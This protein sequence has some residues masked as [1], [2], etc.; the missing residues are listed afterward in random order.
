MTFDYCQFIMMNILTTNIPF[1]N[2][3]LVA[4]RGGIGRISF[5]TDDLLDIVLP[6]ENVHAAIVL[7]Y[8]YNHS[9]LYYADVNIDVIKEVDLNNV[10]NTRNLISNG[11]RTTNGLA[12]DWI[13]NNLY[14]SDT[15]SSTI[16]VS[17][18]D[19]SSRKIIVTENLN[20]P[21][22]LAI[23]PQRGYLFFSDW[24]KPQRI[25]RCYLDGS[26]RKIIIST[27]LGFPTGLCI[28]FRY[29]NP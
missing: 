20:D 28:D 26:D 2:Y 7:D 16:E 4:M 24:G 29:V 10:K 19:G 25:E 12:V 15:E 9:K 22:S 27:N 8:H 3:L 17:R 1:Q 23:F 6:I 14:F 11:L 21:R 5:D 18:L 13:A